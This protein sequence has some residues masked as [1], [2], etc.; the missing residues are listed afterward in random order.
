MTETYFTLVINKRRTCDTEN[1]E[2]KLVPIKDR[3]EVISLLTERG[4]DLNGNKI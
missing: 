4:Y 2:V 1:K 3:D